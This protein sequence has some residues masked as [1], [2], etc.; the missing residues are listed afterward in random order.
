M[1]IQNLRRHRYKYRHEHC[2]KWT[3]NPP[4][5]VQQA[6]HQDSTKRQANPKY[7]YM[8]VDAKNDT[9]FHLSA[10]TENRGDF[11]KTYQ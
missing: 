11:K 6:S 5:H 8:N 7:G 3:D 1:E 9:F 10:T 4:R 2:H